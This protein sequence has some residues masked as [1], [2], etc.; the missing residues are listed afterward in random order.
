MSL[1]SDLELC[2]GYAKRLEDL[3]EQR[4]QAQD[5]I[6]F[7]QTEGDRLKK[8]V[9]Y[10]TIMGAC[11]TGY[12]GLGGIVGAVKSCSE[13]GFLSSMCLLLIFSGLATVAFTIFNRRRR[14]ASEALKE[15]KANKPALLQQY[16]AVIENCEREIADL[17]DEIYEEELTEIVPEAYFSV[18]AIEFCLSQVQK[19]LANTATE[20]FRQLDAEIKRLEHMEYLE[21]MNDAQLEQLSEIKR[22]IDVN[23]MV[24]VAGQIRRNS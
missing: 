24:N 9:R 4:V 3:Q 2:L 20:V 11:A 7:L 5:S 16:T 1:K 6:V 19:K 23:T 18:A 21:Q 8:S 12:L 17:I 22:A 13:L 10:S 15:I 14:S